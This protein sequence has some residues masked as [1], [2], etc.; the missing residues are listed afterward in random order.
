[1]KTVRDTADAVQ[2]QMRF[3]AAKANLRYSTRVIQGSP[4]IEPA[5][6]DADLIVI[7]THGRTGFGQVLIGRV[8]ERVVRHAHCPV[9][10]IPAGPTFDEV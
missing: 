2:K 8:A 9:L 6:E 3:M 4:A 7:S 10:V 1:M 5:N